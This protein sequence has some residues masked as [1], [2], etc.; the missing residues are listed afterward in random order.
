MRLLLYRILTF[1]DLKLNWVCTFSH[2]K[3]WHNFNLGSS[4]GCKMMHV[5]F[6]P[7]SGQLRKHSTW[8]SM[9]LHAAITV[10]GK[11]LTGER[12]APWV[13]EDSPTVAYACRVP[14]LA[15]HWG[16]QEEEAILKLATLKQMNSQNDTLGD[17]LFPLGASSQLKA[18]KWCLLHIRSEMNFIQI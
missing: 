12:R 5:I 2:A 16:H 17:I 1:I 9:F 13:L 7:D 8:K 11:R 15:L 10:R 18:L 3:Y 4:K 14:W 6:A